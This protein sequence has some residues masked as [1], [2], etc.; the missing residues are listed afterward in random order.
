MDISVVT[1]TTEQTE[2]IGYAALLGAR[3]ERLPAAVRRRFGGRVE[4]ETRVYIGEVLVTELSLAGRILAQ[5]AR[6]VGGPIPF[7]P[8]AVGP[9]V[10][11]VTQVDGYGRDRI[12]AEVWTRS[13]VRPRRFPQVIQ[14]AKCLTG[15]T[16][17]EER[18]GH[19][20]SMQLSVHA[21]GAQGAAELVFRSTGYRLELGWLS[22]P[23]PAAISPG[24]CEVR[25]CDEGDRAF[26]FKLTI[27]HPLLGRL[28][29]QVARYRDPPEKE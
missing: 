11:S 23:L 25:H 12:R 17:L 24:Q 22:L 27:T 16:G 29:H 9:S 4:N 28:I 26:I 13:Y 10:V 8:G 1:E 7:T 18:L 20:L 5:L 3:W 2:Q 14:S 19:G 6:L 15:P 21:D